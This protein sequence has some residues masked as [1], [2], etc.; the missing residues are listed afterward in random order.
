MSDEQTRIV[1][2]HSQPCE[3]GRQIS[4]WP[5]GED[6][7]MC[8]GGREIVEQAVPWCDPHDEQLTDVH[9]DI[10]TRYFGKDTCRL[11]DPPKVWRETQ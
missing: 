10:F 8:P 6:G 3:H 1:R 5:E 7:P 4:H 9:R 2:D 11:Q